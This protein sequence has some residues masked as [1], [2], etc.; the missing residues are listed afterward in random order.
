MPSTLGTP[1]PDWTR[2]SKEIPL[3]L[4]KLATEGT[5]TT[6]AGHIALIN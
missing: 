4:R 2:N 5:L 3:I 6:R 1:G